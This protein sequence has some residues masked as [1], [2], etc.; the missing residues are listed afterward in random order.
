M[1]GCLIKSPRL[2]NEKMVLNAS[3]KAPASL[4]Y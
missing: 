1:V 2:K 4:D 3:F